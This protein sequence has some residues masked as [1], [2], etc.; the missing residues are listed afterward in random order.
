MSLTTGTGRPPG[1]PRLNRQLHQANPRVEPA[2]VQDLGERAA[3]M[4]LSLSR[5]LSLLVSEVHDYTGSFT[6]DVR[7]ELGTRTPM[8]VLRDRVATRAPEDC[9]SAPAGPSVRPG[10]RIDKPLAEI[11][12]ARCRELDVAYDSYLRSILRDAVYGPSTSRPEQL[13][14]LRHPVRRG[15]GA[16]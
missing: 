15:E 1:R 16:A 12:S 7:P 9:P 13:A 14:L 3:G 8:S 4:Q 6:P 5:Y 10:V 2:I 11:I